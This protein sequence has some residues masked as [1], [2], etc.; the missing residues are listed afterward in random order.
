M[1]AYT[2]VKT[3]KIKDRWL[4]ILH[5]GAMVGIFIY[6]VVF[7]VCPLAS[8]FLAY[9]LWYYQVVINHGYL[10]LESPVGNARFSFRR[11]RRNAL[12]CER[13]WDLP[14]PYIPY[15]NTINPSPLAELQYCN[16]TF[17]SF[18][19]ATIQKGDGCPNIVGT[20]LS[21][22]YAL[23]RS[24]ISLDRQ[25]QPALYLLGRRRRHIS[26]LRI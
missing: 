15:T 25:Q 18:T 17:W 24:P 21:Y 23:R 20:T 19:Q 4:G 8:M 7:T 11:V 1:F 12:Y 2:T 22:R 16:S 3:V 6:I 13:L 10:F 26:R 14:Q 9:S 5:Y